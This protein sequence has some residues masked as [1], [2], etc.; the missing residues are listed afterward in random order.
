VL[1]DRWGIPHITAET[2]DDLFFAQGFVRAQDRL[3]QMDLWRRSVQRR[4]SDVDDFGFGGI[5]T[6]HVMPHTQNS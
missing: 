3:F 6:P 2:Q 4:L 5:N 1:R